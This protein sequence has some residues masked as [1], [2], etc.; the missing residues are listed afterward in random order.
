MITI[1][2]TD[3][4]SIIEVMDSNAGMSGNGKNEEGEDIMVEVE[5]DYVCVTTFQHN[6]WI[7]LNYY[8]RDG[9]TEEVYDGKWD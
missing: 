4:D 5:T 1:D 2:P 9:T 7:R 8:W 3:Y 6:H